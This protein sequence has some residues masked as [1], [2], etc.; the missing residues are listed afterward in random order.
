MRIRRLALAGA[1]AV[2]TLAAAALAAGVNQAS[3][4]PQTAFAAQGITPVRTCATLALVTFADGSHVTSAVD[5]DASGSTPRYCEVTVLIPDRINI[6]VGG[7]IIAAGTMD[8]LRAQSGGANQEL[9]DIFLKLTGGAGFQ[10]IADV[11]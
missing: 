11:V 1:A 10:E 2:L 4:T 9:T 5:R 7:K 6:I 3:A 8:E